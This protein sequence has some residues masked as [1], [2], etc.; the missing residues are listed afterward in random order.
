MFQECSDKFYC[1]R[2]LS[3]ITFVVLNICKNGVIREA[4][5]Q[6]NFEFENFAGLNSTLSD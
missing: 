5:T 3:R 1:P 4:A 6:L 2:L